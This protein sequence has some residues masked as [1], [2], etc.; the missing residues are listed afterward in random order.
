MGERYEQ[1]LICKERG[2]Q[3][4]YAVTMNDTWNHCR[5][6]GTGYR[7]QTTQLEQNEPMENE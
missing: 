7:T 6:C 2:H 5:F 1:Y 3:F 4:A